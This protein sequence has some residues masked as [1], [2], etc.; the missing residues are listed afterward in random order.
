MNHITD[1]ILN[2]FID[3]ELSTA[4]LSL[5]NDHIKVCN[6][7]LARL[8]AQKV[9]DNN[10]K[11]I[12]TYQAPFKFTEKVMRKISATAV[13]FK[14]KKS[15]FFRVVFS[16]FILG[17]LAVVAIAFANIPADT[18]NSGSTEWTK[19]FSSFISKLFSGY[20]R[21]ISKSSIS[22]IGTILTFILFVSGYFVFESHRKIKNQI[23]KMG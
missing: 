2:K 19:I 3:N 15:Y 16:V 22:L 12:E 18:S 21:S 23:N 14:P 4:E 9:V 6:E 17:S 8:K 10:L 1:E 5:L 11:R 13:K 20:E 7:C